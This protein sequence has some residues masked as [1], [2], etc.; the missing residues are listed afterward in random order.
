MEGLHEATVMH[1]AME[2]LFKPPDFRFAE[3]QEPRFSSTSVKPIDYLGV[4]HKAGWDTRI[5]LSGHTI[6]QESGRLSHRK[7]TI[8]IGKKIGI[9]FGTRKQEGWRFYLQKQCTVCIYMWRYYKTADKFS[10]LR[11]VSS[12]LNPMDYY[13]WIK[14]TCILKQ[15]YQIPMSCEEVWPSGAGQVMI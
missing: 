12:Y 11:T 7:H 13:R 8:K 15:I 9:V 1:E 4:K 3:S 6:D 2:D 5:P 14:S 10:W